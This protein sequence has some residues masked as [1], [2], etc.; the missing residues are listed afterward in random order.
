MNRHPLDLIPSIAWLRAYQ[1]RHE[2]VI[3]G[4]RVTVSS[5]RF[6]DPRQTEIRPIADRIPTVS[7]RLPRAP[8]VKLS[9]MNWRT[10]DGRNR[11]NRS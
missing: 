3:V 9:S 6:L 5:R 2:I 8:C 1:K 4:R 10:T 11:K 7:K